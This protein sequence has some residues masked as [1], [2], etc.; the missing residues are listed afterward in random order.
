MTKFDIYS[1][2]FRKSDS[3]MSHRANQTRART[4]GA[5][6]DRTSGSSPEPDMGS[7]TAVRNDS[8]ESKPRQTSSETESGSPIPGSEAESKPERRE[9]GKSLTG[10][11]WQKSGWVT[12]DL[13]TFSCSVVYSL[14]SECGLQS[15]CGVLSTLSGTTLAK[16]TRSLCTRSLNI[17][18]RN[19]AAS[20]R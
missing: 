5:H 10:Q 15:T 4:Q 7:R 16:C 3:D 14:H 8:G 2:L 19:E 11:D 17:L 20:P 18:R 6:R 12:H 9:K 1:D 13:H